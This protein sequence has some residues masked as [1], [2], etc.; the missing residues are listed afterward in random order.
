MVDN[1]QIERAMKATLDN[2]EEFLR[3]SE[4]LQKHG[5]I[6]HATS[7]AI[8]GFEEAHKAYLISL[9]HSLFDGIVSED[10]RK[11]LKHHFSKHPWKQLHAKEFRAGLEHLMKSG[12]LPEDIRKRL[13]IPNLSEI[14][15]G[16]DYAFSMRLDR[17]KNDGFYTD[18]FRNP[19]W[20]PSGIN[21]ETLESVQNLASTQIQSVKRTVMSLPMLDLL[22]SRL[23]QSIRDE[24]IGV[25]SALNEA[26]KESAY[27][28]NLLEK[29]LSEFGDGGK[30]VASL[31]RSYFAGERMKQIEKEKKRLQT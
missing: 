11:Q 29:K 5:S 28:I 4:R 24:L 9:F 16:T 3:D 23:L 31:T 7:L 20:F 12:E 15:Q 6:G 22:P 8:L 17:M 2:A 13:G 27:D 26:Q 21:V 30:I 18:P 14:E 10:Y 25:A 1:R 19:V